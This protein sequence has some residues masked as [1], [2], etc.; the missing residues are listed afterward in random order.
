MHGQEAELL[1]V[2]PHDVEGGHGRRR[3]LVPV[4]GGQAG[5]QRGQAMGVEVYSVA[6][7]L[8]RADRP[9]FEHLDV[10]AA[11]R[12]PWARHRPPRPA[13]AMSYL[14]LLSFLEPFVSIETVSDG[15]ESIEMTL[16]EI[17]SYG[18]I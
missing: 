14:H 7:G 13:P 3:Q 9:A 10:D 8:V 18:T 1:V 11:W 12:S 2:E 15:T 5:A 6:G 4:G 17:V 16:H